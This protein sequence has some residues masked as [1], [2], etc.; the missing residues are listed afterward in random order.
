MRIL[1][2]FKTYIPDSFTGIERV[3]W[4][5]GEGLAD[6][7]V[8]THVLSLSTKPHAGIYQVGRH[9][10]HQAKQ[11]FHFASAGWSLDIF[12]VFKKLSQ[13]VDV[14]HY[15]FPWP[16]A[17]LLHLVTRRGTPSLVTYHS[18]VVRQKF[19]YPIYKPLMSRFLGEVDAIVATSPNYKESSPVL[20][21]FSE[22]VDIIPIGIKDSTYVS[23]NNVKRWKE[24][25]GEGFFLFIGALRYY[26]GLGTLLEAARITGFPVVIAGDGEMF[27]E[28]SKTAG[29]GVK[30]LGSVSEEDK[31]A[32]LSLCTAFVFPSH[33]RSEAFG[34][35]LLEAS[36][37]ARPMIS[38]EIGTGTT[39]VNIDGET[40][41]VVPPS[42][43]DALA[44]AMRCFFGNPRKAEEMG[45]RARARYEEFFTSE[46]MCQKYLK[47][48]HS[49][50]E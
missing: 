18:D 4:E 9:F 30:L 23:N 35:A 15:H 46:M 19:L 44:T 17:D 40:G 41:L 11:N 3:I 6:N 43:P 22:K 33:L 7:G 50:I 27:E 25:I 34:V 1:H 12:S 21:K 26:K 10:G 45:K 47:L 5:L 48:Y 14:V 42:D 29:G 49:L 32:L 37:S 20:K 36:R 38:C 2:V 39:F 16:T 8:E 24:E 31:L 28:I 13:D